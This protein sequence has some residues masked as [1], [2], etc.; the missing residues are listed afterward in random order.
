MKPRI[1]TAGPMTAVA[2]GIKMAH[3]MAAALA[4]KP[5]YRRRED[6]LALSQEQP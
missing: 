5:F 6:V 1:W 2:G 4:V 3:R